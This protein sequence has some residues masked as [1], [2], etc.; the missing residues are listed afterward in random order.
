MTK[1]KTTLIQED[2]PK[3]TAPN[4]YRPI[5]CLPIVRKILIA[6]IREEIYDSLTSHG[7]FPEDQRG[8]C[9]GFKEKNGPEKS[10]YGLD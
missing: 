2:L 9:K 3:G 1:G 6:Q 8:C 7:L 10:C 5:T 4:N